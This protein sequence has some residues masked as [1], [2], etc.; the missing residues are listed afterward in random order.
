MPKKRS[1][2]S[3]GS[4]R[5]VRV[6]PARAY[7]HLR[8][9]DPRLGALIDEHGPFTPRPSA[10]P[11]GA[12]V[13]SIFFLLLAGAAATAIMGRTF[14]LFGAAD[15]TPEPADFLRASDA[16]LRGAG[17]S[18]QKS[19]YLRD[20]AQHVVDGRLRF[21]AVDAMDDA[22]VIAHLTAVKG[23]GEW[24]AHMFLMFHLGRP[25]VLPVGD[26]GVRKGMQAV[27]GL[28][29]EPDPKRATKIGA[30]WAPYRSVGAWY[31]WR[32]VETVTPD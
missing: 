27:Y 4:R 11:Y 25:D 14:A 2:A 31:M 28:R 32:A 26:L 29:T 6:S 18:R 7:R 9:A 21:D 13:R 30:P 17:L 3:L 22:E 19:G 10:D 24:S 23:I 5:R 12:L 8:E 16:E 15:T 20:L 1:E